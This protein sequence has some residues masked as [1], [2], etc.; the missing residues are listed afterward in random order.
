[1]S[2]GI[3]KIENLTNNKIYI[4][5]SINIEERFKRHMKANDEFLI[6]KA[7]KKY[8]IENF[9]FVIIEECL[10]K[11]LDKKEQYWIEQY[12]SL[13]PNGYNMIT[14]GSNGAGLAKG[15]AVMQYSLNGDYIK[16]YDSAHQAADALN[17][18]FGNICA[19]CRGDRN[20]TGDFQWKYVDSDKN[21]KVSNARHSNTPILQY[22]LNGNFIK[23]YATLKE[24]AEAVGCSKALICKVCKGQGKTAKNFK[25][26]YKE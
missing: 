16:T 18:D 8:G 4:G 17:L 24:A 20:Q 26:K 21:I 25:W 6:H 7:F 12:N 10:A 15:K 11:D 5:Q 9:S 2:C 3:Y 1:M 22:D 13:A 14:G 23:E 19:C